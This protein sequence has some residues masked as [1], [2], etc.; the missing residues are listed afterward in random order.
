[1]IGNSGTITT[2]GVPHS[3][4]LSTDGILYPNIG[5]ALIGLDVEDV[6]DDGGWVVTG[7]GF[8]PTNVNVYVSIVVPSHASPGYTRRPCYSSIQGQGWECT[9]TDGVS[10]KFVVPPL[11][12]YP[13]RSDTPTPFNPF[14][15]YLE[16]VDGTLSFTATSLLTVVHRSYTTNLYSVRSHFPPPRNVGPPLDA[17]EYDG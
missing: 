17:E 9:S 15:I 6:G 4:G 10:L 13:P 14:D 7:S 2:T 11:P 5:L 12:I 16:T 1:M 3:L 8:F